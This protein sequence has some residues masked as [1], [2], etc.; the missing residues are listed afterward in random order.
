MP[1]LDAYVRVSQ[2]RGRDGD[3]FISPA[4]Q[5]DRIAAWAQAHGH[6]IAKVHDELDASGGTVDRPKLNEVM[7]RIEA[8]ETGG[9][10]V[11]KLDRFGRTLV[12]SLALVE[13]IEEAGGTFASVNDGFDL[14]TD[15]G[16]LVLRIMLSLAEF[17][18]DRIR[19]NWDEAQRRAVERGLHPSAIVPFGYERTDGRPLEPHPVNGPLVTRLFELRAEGAAWVDLRTFLAA[20]GAQTQR[21]RDVWTLRATRDIIRNDVYLGIASHGEHRKDGAHP[22]LT[23]PATWRRAQRRGTQSVSRAADPALLTGLLRCAGCR[24]AMRPVTR[25]L[26]DGRIVHD[27]R[28]RCGSEKAGSCPDAATATGTDAIEEYVVNRFLERVKLTARASTNGK[29]AALE[30]AL[31]RAQQTLDDYALDTD[32]QATLPIETYRAG[33]DIR[34]RQLEAACAALDA[35]HDET[36]VPA[37][38]VETLREDWPTLTVD[39][40]RRLLAVVIDCVFVRRRAGGEPIADRTHICWRGEAPDLPGKGRRNYEP[41]PFLFDA[42]SNIRPTGPED[43]RVDGA[44]GLGKVAV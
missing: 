25:K 17:E 18:L 33:L 3:S 42:P 4:I 9:I 26:A 23:D 30:A 38:P 34:R 44:G 22:A 36:A 32:L 16:R 8:G 28:C 12:D 7:R 24:Y 35:K 5:R 39:E 27:Y 10:V 20:Q 29:L 6:R 19:G 13:R 43:G 14:S 21:G 2:V 11:F 1:T 40:R 15:T 31:V 41:R 37:L